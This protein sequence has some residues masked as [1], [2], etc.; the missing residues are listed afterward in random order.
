MRSPRIVIALRRAAAGAVLATGCATHEP[1]RPV[2]R[3]DAALAGTVRLDSVSG[4][5]A[6]EG[7][8]APRR[9]DGATAALAGIFGWVTAPLEAGATIG[10]RGFGRCVPGTSDDAWCSMPTRLGALAILQ[11]RS[12][13]DHAAAVGAVEAAL[14]PDRLA[15][16]LRASL[17]ARSGGQMAGQTDRTAPALNVAI[18]HLALKAAEAGG[19][20]AD[21]FDPRMRLELVVEA[22]LQRPGQQASVGRWAYETIHRRYY[23]WASDDA[24]G[25][26]AELGVA[27][28]AIADAIATSLF[29]PA[30]RAP[31]ASCAGRTSLR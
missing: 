27:F 1:L 8:A 18:T 11:Y 20:A 10:G 22:R 19:S 6:V 14:A 16:C 24:E 30:A 7:P 15:A 29:P 26:R 31:R 17:L 28:G 13:Q 5:P 21:Q 12:V 4:P 23:E 3:L 9:L 25:L 2:H